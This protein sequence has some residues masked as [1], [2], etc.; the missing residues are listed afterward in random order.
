M[1]LALAMYLLDGLLLLEPGELVLVRVRG[2]KWRPQFGAHGWKLSG[3]EPFLPNPLTPWRPLVRMRC[4][5]ARDLTAA[6]RA[7]RI[8]LPVVGASAQAAVGLLLG[9]IFVA[10]PACLFVYPATPVTVTVV[11]LIYASSAASLWFI[12]AQRQALG[13]SLP[14]FAKLCGESIVC[15]PLCLNAVRKASL[16]APARVS[17]ADLMAELD[18]GPSL[19]RLRHELH[20]RIVAEIEAE[21]EGSERMRRL[22]RAQD[23][24]EIGGVVP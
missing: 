22:R 6:G 24:L 20:V 15:P 3:R 7:G 23:A 5:L 12:H 10:L 2:G 8:A 14:A 4:D 21:P 18:P 1:L 11:V 16:R 9:L 17:L 19:D 13:M